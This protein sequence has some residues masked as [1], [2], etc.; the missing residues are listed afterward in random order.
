MFV[1]LFVFWYLSTNLIVY[2]LLSTRKREYWRG[3]LWGVN[4][5]ILSL[6]GITVITIISN[7]KPIEKLPL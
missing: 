6:F 4:F 5:T 1:K 7:G 3:M 2:D